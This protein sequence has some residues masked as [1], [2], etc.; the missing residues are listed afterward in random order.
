MQEDGARCRRMEHGAGCSTTCLLLCPVGARPRSAGR[1]S[2]PLALTP[3][4]PQRV[5]PAQAGL[6]RDELFP[7]YLPEGAFPTTTLSLGR[8]SSSPKGRGFA[9]RHSS[10][11]RRFCRGP[12]S[13][14]V[15]SARGAPSR[16]P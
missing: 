14:S 13:T 7:L 6:E 10:P 12:F 8:L 11:G 4:I 3:S 9:L 5:S 2:R 15:P 1:V 16:L